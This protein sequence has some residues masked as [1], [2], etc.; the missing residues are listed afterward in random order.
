MMTVAIFKPTPLVFFIIMSNSSFIFWYF[1]SVRGVNTNWK[2]IRSIHQYFSFNLLTLFPEIIQETFAVE[3][4]FSQ[5]TDCR[6]GISMDVV[7]NLQ[8]IRTIS[9]IKDKICHNLT[10]CEQFEATHK[11]KRE[12]WPEIG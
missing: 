8:T 10:L 5:F 6:T 7:S 9:R 3:L 2:E 4:T 12:H 11:T 1:I